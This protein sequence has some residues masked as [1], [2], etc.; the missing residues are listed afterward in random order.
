MPRSKAAA[1][2]I[3]SS[4]KSCYA[5]SSETGER[6]SC[7]FPKGKGV[8]IPVNMYAQLMA[9]EDQWFNPRTGVMEKSLPFADDLLKKKLAMEEVFSAPVEPAEENVSRMGDGDSPKVRKA[10]K[11]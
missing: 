3:T 2:R 9:F 5:Y 11:K 8:L 4:E 7:S 6:F 10:K 1:I